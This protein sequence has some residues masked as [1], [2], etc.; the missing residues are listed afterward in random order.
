MET[1]L[2]IEIGKRKM[3]DIH[4]RKRVCRCLTSKV[5]SLARLAHGIP[6]TNL[7]YGEYQAYLDE[8]NKVWARLNEKETLVYDEM[9]TAG[10]KAVEIDDIMRKCES[11]PVDE[12]A[13]YQAYP[14]TI[15]L[16]YPSS[17]DRIEENKR[18]IWTIGYDS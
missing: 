12:Y 13:I 10:V 5:I 17:Q 4:Y 11:Y 1:N 8:L 9:I 16:R 18:I 2:A 3:A 15:D 7:R 14:I 6:G